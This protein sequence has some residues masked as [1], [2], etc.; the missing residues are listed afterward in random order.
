MIFNGLV[1]YDKDLNLTGDLAESWDIQE[2]GLVIIFT[3]ARTFGGRTTI[4][5]PRRM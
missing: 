1:K 5:S 2:G 4:R 3:Y